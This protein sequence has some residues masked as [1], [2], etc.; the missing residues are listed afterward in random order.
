MA[1][2]IGGTPPTYGTN[3]FG[4]TTEPT[5]DIVVPYGKTE[6]Y[7]EKWLITSTDEDGYYI[8]SAYSLSLIQ[9][10]YEYT[11]YPTV[12]T[13]MIMYSRYPLKNFSTVEG[14][15]IN[16][17]KLRAYAAADPYAGIEFDANEK[18]YV[19][20]AYTGTDTELD[21]NEMLTSDANSD[22][23]RTATVEKICAY[24]FGGNSTLATLK[25]PDRIKN[26][27]NYAFIECSVLKTIYL[28]GD[29]SYIPSSYSIDQNSFNGSFL[30]SDMKI[31]V[32]SAQLEKYN[33]RWATRCPS[34]KGRFEGVL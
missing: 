34:L 3:A 25:L 29:G 30:P 2:F 20:H 28:I 26:I 16:Y 27:E 21:L 18:Y 6:V 32:P 17:S 9:H 23:E 10:I 4:G 24:A 8:P 12:V 15:T 33:A 22:G 11:V 19:I 7:A 14:E 5:A 31:Y 13:G 1:Y